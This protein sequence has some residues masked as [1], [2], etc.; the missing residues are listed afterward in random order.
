[1]IALSMREWNGVKDFPSGPKVP[2]YV[3]RNEG[4]EW[5]DFH[6]EAH[7]VYLANDSINDFPLERLQNDRLGM[8]SIHQGPLEKQIEGVDRK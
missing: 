2:T 5:T 8:M 6:K 1:M 3:T 7:L 4:L